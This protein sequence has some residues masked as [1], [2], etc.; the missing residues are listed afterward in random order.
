MQAQGLPYF[1]LKSFFTIIYQSLNLDEV[2][3]RNS[4]DK[5]HNTSGKQLSEICVTHD[6]KVL[7]G[8]TVGDMT[9]KITCFKY[10]GCSIV[11]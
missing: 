8:R 3:F 11:D 4:Q 2:F 6:L 7:N 1:R 5:N 10:N 9:G